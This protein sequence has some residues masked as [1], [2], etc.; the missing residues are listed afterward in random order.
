MVVTGVFITYIC[1]WFFAFL[2]IWDISYIKIFKKIND[3]TQEAFDSKE[4]QRAGKGNKYK[5]RN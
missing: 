1:F 2:G 5:S 4:T 3:I